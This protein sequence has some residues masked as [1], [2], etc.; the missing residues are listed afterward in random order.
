MNSGGLAQEKLK[1]VL[2]VQLRVVP[3]DLAIAL[4]SGEA[5]ACEQ[6]AVD[7]RPHECIRFLLDQVQH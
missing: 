5:I 1:K 4:K 2:Q 3:P 7:R 6:D